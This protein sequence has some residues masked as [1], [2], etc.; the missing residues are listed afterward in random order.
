MPWGEHY[1]EEHGAAPAQ[2][3]LRLRLVLALIGVAMFVAIAV[4]LARHN[5]PAGY[6]VAPLLLA[7]VGAVDVV[8]VTIRLHRG[9][10]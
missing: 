2:S 10:H 4:V 9:R 7:L 5:V 6:V 3:A 8:V 1:F